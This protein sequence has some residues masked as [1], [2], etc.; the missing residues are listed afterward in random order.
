MSDFG[1]KVLG[2]IVVGY[3]ILCIITLIALLIESEI[4]KRDWRKWE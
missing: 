3:F 2:I 4:N 1:K